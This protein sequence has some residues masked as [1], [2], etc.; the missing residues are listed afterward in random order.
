MQFTELTNVSP[1]IIRATQ[2]MGFTDMT[3]IQEKANPLMLGGHDLIAKAPTAKRWRS[4][5]PSCPRWTLPA[6]SRR[7][8]S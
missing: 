5:S 8:S 4:V 3:E 2:A 7:Q 1:E 6:S